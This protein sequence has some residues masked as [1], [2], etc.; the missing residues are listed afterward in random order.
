MLQLS[1][2]SPGKKLPKDSILIDFTT[3][4][5]FECFNLSVQ[6]F[7]E[8]NKNKK[9]ITI[10]DYIYPLGKSL[11]S[12]L[13]EIKDHV[14]LTGKNPLK[15]A[16]FIPLSNIYNSKNG[17]VVAGLENGTVPNDHE[18]KVLQ[19]CDIKAYCYNLVPTV[20]LS[21]FLKLNISAYGV[22]KNS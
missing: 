21:A 22:L 20:I 19:D 15:G 1:T 18:I 14:N 6:S 12:S 11:K 10:I 4:G 2:K 5:N 13:I 16:L 8:K 3:N 9:K 7:L 17:I